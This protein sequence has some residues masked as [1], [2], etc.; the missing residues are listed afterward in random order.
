MSDVKRPVNLHK[1]YHAHIYFDASTLPLAKQLGVQANEQFGLKVGRY[2]ERSVGP[3][4]EWS[5]QIIFSQKDFAA[6]IPWLDTHRQGLTVLVHGI[7]GDD[8][9][10]HTDYAYWLGEPAVL[11]L[12]LFS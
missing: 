10:D 4:P 12:A 9:K 11:N 6:F 3:H 7:T 1:A 8:L 5:V 2:H